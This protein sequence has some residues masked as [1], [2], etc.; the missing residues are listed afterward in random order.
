M[1][2]AVLTLSRDGEGEPGRSGPLLAGRETDLR[3]LLGAL[4]A[5]RSGYGSAVVLTGDAGIGKSALAGR[6]AMV[7]RDA[8][9]HVSWGAGWDG[10]PRSPR[11]TRRFEVSGG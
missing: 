11:A 1:D 4:D 6:L 9:W 3:V 8:G 7:A 5:A 10:G 2:G